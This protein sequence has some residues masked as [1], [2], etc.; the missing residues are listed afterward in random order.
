MPQIVTFLLG[1]LAAA[2]LAYLLRRRGMRKIR[3]L[4]HEKEELL[5]EESRMFS[6]LHEIGENLAYD[7]GLRRLHEDIVQGVARVVGADSTALY[8]I[9]PRTGVDLVPAALTKDCPAVIELPEKLLGQSAAAL[10]SYLQLTAVPATEGLLGRCFTS[11]TPVNTGPLMQGPH[12][13]VRLASSQA[14]M[15]VMVAPVTTGSRKLGVLAA[16]QNAGKEPF[17]G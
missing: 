10:H 5:T 11:Q 14:G 3:G 1:F 16:I 6:F 4:E 13:N 17:T 12:W 2:A 7:R 8:L 15:S 9:D